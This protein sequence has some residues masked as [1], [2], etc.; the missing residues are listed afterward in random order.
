MSVPALMAPLLGQFHPSAPG[1]SPVLA[2]SN[3]AVDTP[4]LV[5]QRERVYLPS[6]LL[7]AAGTH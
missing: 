6:Y 4:F 5:L 1:V 3:L 7:K 2:S